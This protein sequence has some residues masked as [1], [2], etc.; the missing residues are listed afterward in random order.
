MIA[1][2]ASFLCALNGVGCLVLSVPQEHAGRL[3]QTFEDLQ[4]AGLAMPGSLEI[5]ES[6]L[7]QQA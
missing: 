5:H 7:T 4:G 2:P 1:D 3:R 6:D